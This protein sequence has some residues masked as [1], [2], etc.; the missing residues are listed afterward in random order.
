MGIKL[1]LAAKLLESCIR[2]CWRDSG[3]LGYSR[4]RISL[5]DCQSMKSW[6]EAKTLKERLLGQKILS[7]L[8]E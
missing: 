2:E 8:K 6:L 3:F 1:F 5:N 7:E 4:D